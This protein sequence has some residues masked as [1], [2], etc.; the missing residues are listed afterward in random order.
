MHLIR[1]DKLISNVINDHFSPNNHVLNIKIYKVHGMPSNWDTRPIFLLGQRVK[2]MLR[3]GKRKEP[4][5]TRQEEGYLLIM[6]NR[7]FIEI[8][9][10][11]IIIKILQLMT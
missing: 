5:H 10:T 1:L 6:H 3:K 9:I 7:A 4:H 11:V 2:L 8:T